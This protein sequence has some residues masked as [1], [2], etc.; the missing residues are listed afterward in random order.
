MKEKIMKIILVFFIV[1]SVLAVFLS[2]RITPITL[3]RTTFVYEYGTEISTNPADYVNGN[4]KI[5]QDVV[6]NL[7]N[8]K[9]EIGLY[10]ASASYANVNLKFYIKIQDTTKPVATLKQIVFNVNL[11]EKV[12]ALNLLDKVEDN[13]DISAYFVDDE[14]K[15]KGS[16]LVFNEKGS[17]V[18]NII[19]EDTSGNRASKLRVKLVAGRKGNYPTLTGINTVEVVK[20]HKFDPMEGVKASDGNGNDITGSIKILKN[21]VDVKEVG[22]YEV[23]YSVTNADGNNLQRTRKVVVIKSESEKKS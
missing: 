12:Y 7:K 11:G 16:Y 6:L 5:M 1:V 17:Y 4:E 15:K 18:E 3:K 2:L 13:S 10:K 14:N 20:G 21:N 9:N 8:V 22:T 23:I 19:V